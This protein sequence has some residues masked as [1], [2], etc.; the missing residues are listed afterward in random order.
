MYKVLEH[1]NDAAIDLREPQ[2][3]GYASEGRWR[4]L[5]ACEQP[6]WQCPHAL[7]GRAEEQARNFY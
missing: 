3:S 6:A 4:G 2:G 5:R 7:M 1:R